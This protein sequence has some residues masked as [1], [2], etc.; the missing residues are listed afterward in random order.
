MNTL[1]IE[2]LSEEWEEGWAACSFPP[3]SL[4]HDRERRRP[5]RADAL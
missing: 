4:H 3:K 2:A 5:G 1:I